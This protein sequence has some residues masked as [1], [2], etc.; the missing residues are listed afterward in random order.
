MVWMAWV[1]WDANKCVFPKKKA[2]DRSR[3]GGKSERED[4]ALKGGSKV[5][6]KKR[7]NP[8]LQVDTAPE[9]PIE[10]T[11]PLVSNQPVSGL[12]L[13]LSCISHA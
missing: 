12:W 9:V 2:T 13:L 7:R 3:T 6:K 10:A 5:T 1:G 8:N 11:L 4:V